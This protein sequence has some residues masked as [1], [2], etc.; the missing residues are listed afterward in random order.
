MI[1]W[2]GKYIKPIRK[3]QYNFVILTDLQVFG[4][5]RE[6]IDIFV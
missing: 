6:N 2:L 4:G 5:Y 1:K 3:K